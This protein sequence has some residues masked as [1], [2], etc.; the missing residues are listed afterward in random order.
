M[1]SGHNKE[2][3]LRVNEVFIA[4]YTHALKDFSKL[5]DKIRVLEFNYQPQNFFFLITSFSDLH[6]PYESMSFSALVP[7]FFGWC[8]VLFCF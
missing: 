7:W 1:E 4:K 5:E 6:L 8:F 2:D 3:V